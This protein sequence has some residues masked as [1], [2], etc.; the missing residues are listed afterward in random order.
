MSN[1]KV[2]PH[3]LGDILIDLNEDFRG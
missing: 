2:I 1:K 3:F